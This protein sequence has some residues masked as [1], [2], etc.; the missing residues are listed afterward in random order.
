MKLGGLFRIYTTHVIRAWL[1]LRT[2]PCPASS[3][4]A[5]ISPGSADSSALRDLV[6]A[7]RFWLLCWRHL[8]ARPPVSKPTFRIFV[9]GFQFCQDLRQPFSSGK[10]LRGLVSPRTIKAPNNLYDSVVALVQQNSGCPIL[11]FLLTGKGVMRGWF[12]IAVR[13]V[14]ATKERCAGVVAE[15]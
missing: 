3:C 4:L 14:E 1:C 12:A 6:T 13:T 7:C 15:D 5:S 10:L 11:S 8:P 9:D 2:L